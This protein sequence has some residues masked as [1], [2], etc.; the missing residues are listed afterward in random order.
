MSSTTPPSSGNFLRAFGKNARIGVNW[1]ARS[2]SEV[3]GNATRSQGGCYEAA[4]H[5]RTVEPDRTL[6]AT[7]TPATFSLPRPQA[8][9][10]SHDSHRHSLRPQNRHRLGRLAGRTRLR[11][12]QNVPASFATLARSGGVAETPC[13]G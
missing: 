11:L 12:R 6:V 7:G 9:G 4:G 10:P 8:I 2:C 13:H 1:H 3:W 5:R